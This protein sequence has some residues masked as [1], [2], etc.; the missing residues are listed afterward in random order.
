[1]RQEAMQWYG[2]DRAKI[3][4]LYPPVDTDR[5]CVVAPSERARLRRSLG[6]SDDRAV[7]VLASTGHQRKGLGL[8]A[9]WF[10]Q[11]SLPATL[12]VAGRAP[13]AASANLTY[14][15]YRTDMEDIYRAADF[16]VMAS[17]YEPFGLVGVESVLCGTPVVMADDVGC[18]EVVREP[19]SIAFSMTEPEGLAQA[20]ARAV[21][22]WQ[23]GQSRVAQPLDAL[24]YDPRV[25]TH[26][27]ALLALL[28]RL[29]PP[30]QSAPLR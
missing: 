20:L 18:A 19:A 28:E 17:H 27:D 26:L 24:A 10:A 3:E 14:L 13:A 25:A 23:D 16:T 15:G 4:L 22:R 29:R 8:L 1:M 5:F 2:V 7:F 9:R 30:V 11:T 12:V 21:R 6:W